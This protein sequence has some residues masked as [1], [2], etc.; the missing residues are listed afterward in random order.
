MIVDKVK[1]VALDLRR[2]HLEFKMMGSDLK[3]RG[4]KEREIDIDEVISDL[5]TFKLNVTYL[6]LKTR[7]LKKS[8][9]DSDE[10]YQ[11]MH[12]F[13]VY[14]KNAA[15]TFDEIANSMTY[16]GRSGDEIAMQKATEELLIL[17]RQL[18]VINSHL[19]ELND[20]LK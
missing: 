9:S 13:M 1:E 18:V 4:A 12:Y 19:A 15:D 8:N 6:K 2:L 7:E 11:T 20:K 5:G 14:L 10:V 3:V 16:G 17:K